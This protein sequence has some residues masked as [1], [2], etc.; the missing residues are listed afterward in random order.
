MKKIIGTLVVIICLFFYGIIGVGTRVDII[1]KMAPEEISN[2]NW[3][4]MRYE[5]YQLGSFKNHGGKV[6]YH[7]CNID[8]RN[9]QYRVFATLWGGEIHFTYGAPE[10]LRRLSVNYEGNLTSK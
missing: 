9:I 10:T 1:K 5:G 3:E 2:R 6:W 7:V 8:D 4:I